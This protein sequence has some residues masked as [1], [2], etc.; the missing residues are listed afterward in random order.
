MLPHY[1][2]EFNGEGEGAPYPS[3]ETLLCPSGSCPIDLCRCSR[4]RS[5][6]DPM[7]VEDSA[8]IIAD[9]NEQL[10]RARLE[11]ENLE[12]KA[13]ADSGI[14]ERITDA[15]LHRI[16]RLRKELS[17]SEQQRESEAAK[18]RQ[19]SETVQLLAYRLSE[20]KPNSKCQGQCHQD[21]ATALEESK[22]AAA[23]AIRNAE[24][25]DREVV[26]L[27][28][29]LI[30]ANKIVSNERNLSHI[31]SRQVED[32]SRILNIQHSENKEQKVTIANLRQ[33]VKVLQ[34]ENEALL[35][36]RVSAPKTSY[37]DRG[38]GAEVPGA[39]SDEVIKLEAKIAE[40][41]KEIMSLQDQ[42]EEERGMQVVMRTYNATLEHE[43]ARASFTLDKREQNTAARENT[44]PGWVDYTRHQKPQVQHPTATTSTSNSANTD[45]EPRLEL[46]VN[47]QRLS[48]ATTL[49]DQLEK[50]K[51][52]NRD[53]E[54]ELQQL[55][56]VSAELMGFPP[57]R[58]VK[59]HRSLYGSPVQ[60]RSP[61]PAPKSSSALTSFPPLVRVKAH[62][63]LPE[64]PPVTPAVIRS[65]LLQVPEESEEIPE[66][67]LPSPVASIKNGGG[68]DEDQTELQISFSRGESENAEAGTSHATES[69]D[70]HEREGSS[71]KCTTH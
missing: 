12:K 5:P 64:P 15:M 58:R 42:L 44:L 52:K 60:K 18:H 22:K 59:A 41:E 55:R 70:E 24:T 19:A 38:V 67:R 63:S 8:A 9:L 50:L 66:L 37:V 7:E 14:T 56:R 54:E 65:S 29:E 45:N 16:W 10:R 23:E 69:L 28:D 40:I 49:Q 30:A 11:I 1:F 35:A 39:K 43:L 68:Q 21:L 13:E 26:E 2:G 62:G 20:R 32:M 48:T 31:V 4:S 53:L 47:G 71:S 51:Q 34:S 3:D 46:Y 57:L 6:S 36:K 25:R 17:Q 61:K 33:V 27:R